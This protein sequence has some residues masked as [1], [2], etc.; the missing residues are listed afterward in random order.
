MEDTASIKSGSQAP[1]N[2]SAGSKRKRSSDKGA[3]FYAV[4]VGYQPGIY[5]TWADCL[6]QVKGFK[7]SMCML[8]LKLLS[9]L[10]G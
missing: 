4:R 7:K 5:H 9:L 3:K 2:V 1:T 6:E 8:E 10:L